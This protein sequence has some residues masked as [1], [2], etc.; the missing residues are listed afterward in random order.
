MALRPAARGGRRA[1]GRGR[2]AP[3]ARQQPVGGRCCRPPRALRLCSQPRCLF[4]LLLTAMRSVHDHAHGDQDGGGI[5]VHVC[6]GWGERGQ[7]G[8]GARGAAGLKTAHPAC[9]SPSK[10][11][12]SEKSSRLTRQRL[13]DAGATLRFAKRRV[14]QAVDERHHP[15]APAGSTCHC[16]AM[17]QAVQQH[18][19]HWQKPPCPPLTRMSMLHT[20]MSARQTRKAVGRRD[21]R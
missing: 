17:R 20:M 16:Q 12:R 9:H 15:A 11:S 13:D 6:E 19:V 5:Q 21:I 3:G 4:R 8:S 14:R 18:P 7:G 2:F 10:A 1:R